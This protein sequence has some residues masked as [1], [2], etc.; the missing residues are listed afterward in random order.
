[1]RRHLRSDAWS[2]IIS[3]GTVTVGVP[4]S[5]SLGGKEGKKRGGTKFLPPMASAIDSSMAGTKI[6]S[7][8]TTLLLVSTILSLL[9]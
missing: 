9:N 1:M 4:P 7:L 3:V 5:P 2:W 6:I 8:M